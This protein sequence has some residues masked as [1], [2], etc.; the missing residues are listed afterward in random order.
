MTQPS[1][2]NILTHGCQLADVAEAESGFNYYGLVRV[3]GTW[4]IMREK[5]DETEYRFA[6]GNGKVG[7]VYADKFADREQLN[8]R[9]PYEFG[10][11]KV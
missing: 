8:Y 5:T 10:F 2:Y 1:K 11:K 9:L 4:V 3:D 6:V 7:N